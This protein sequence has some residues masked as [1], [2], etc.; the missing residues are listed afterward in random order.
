MSKDKRLVQ[1]IVVVATIFLSFVV[2][3][4][5]VWQYVSP[6][7]LTLEPS[8]QAQVTTG[9]ANVE[10]EREQSV[11]MVRD[12][13]I[14]E[15]GFFAGPKHEYLRKDYLINLKGYQSLQMHPATPDAVKA[16]VILR[17]P[18]TKLLRMDDISAATL[19]SMPAQAFEDLLERVSVVLARASGMALEDYKRNLDEALPITIPA[20]LSADEL[21]MAKSGEVELRRLF[22]ES[23][24]R[25]LS[26]SKDQHRV[27]GWSLTASTGFVG[28]M[29]QTPADREDDDVLINSLTAEQV[30]SFRGKVAQGAKVFHTV[31]GGWNTLA[32]QHQ[33]VSRFETALVVE[34]ASG[35]RYPLW[36]SFVYEPEQARWW[37]KS[38][39]R[40]VSIRAM[41]RLPLVY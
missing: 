22:D 13:T 16:K 30:G 6:P 31:P 10:L 17:E 40:T 20:N 9:P 36:F 29:A 37:L 19:S 18:L 1:R 26:D 3:S 38:S 41:A 27:V 15:A 8:P 24:V 21:N 34:D 39:S 11:A 2:G 5:L 25:S 32:K 35:D 28:R 23:Y 14:D 12:M 7:M 33:V 4:W